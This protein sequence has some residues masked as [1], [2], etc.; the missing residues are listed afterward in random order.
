M[1]EAAVTGPSLG[2]GG[3]RKGSCPSKSSLPWARLIYP[4]TRHPKMPASSLLHLAWL[5]TIPPALTT[6]SK[7]VSW[8]PHLGGIELGLWAWLLSPLPIALIGVEVLVA[9]QITD[10]HFKPTGVGCFSPLL[11]FFFLFLIT[12][13]GAKSQTSKLIPVSK[14]PFMFAVLTNSIFCYSHRYSTRQTY[15]VL[16]PKK[17]WYRSELWQQTS[18]NR[19]GTGRNEVMSG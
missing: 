16:A 18:A 7:H 4:R 13:D 9:W 11:F 5:C 12:W 6:K 19:E 8:C 3:M 10:I 1:T 14:L 15:A 17:L 2:K